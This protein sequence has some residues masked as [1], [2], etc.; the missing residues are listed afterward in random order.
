MKL[1][2]RLAGTEPPPRDA[3][4]SP[5]GPSPASGR[6]ADAS[7]VPPPAPTSSPATSSTATS[8]GASSAAPARGDRRPADPARAPISPAGHDDVVQRRR[9]EQERAQIWTKV[10][11]ELGPQLAL[12]GGIDESELETELTGIIERLLDEDGMSIPAVERARFTRSVLSD[13]LGYGPLDALLQDPDVDEVMCNRYDDVWVERRGRLE[14]TGVAFLDPAQFRHI[15]ERIVAAVGRR[16]DES[17]PMVDARLPDGARINAVLPPIAVN[18]PT[19]TIRKFRDDPFTMD[20]LI[21]YGTLSQGAAQLLDACV[22][23]ELSMIVSGGTGAGK[24]TLLNALSGSIPSDERI[25]TIED[26]AELQLQQDHVITM[27]SRPANVEGRGQVTI[28]DLVRNAL[29]MRPDR[30]VVGEVRGDEAL[31]MLQAM[32]TGHEGSLTTVHANTPR[33]AISRIETLCLMS[34]VELPERAIREQL[35]SAIDVIVQI[36]RRPDGGRR[37][38]AITEVQGLEGKAVLLQDVF[39]YDHASDRLQPTGLRPQLL[40]KLRQRGITVPRSALL[41][42]PAEAGSQD[43]PDDPRTVTS[44]RPRRWTP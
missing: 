32:N 29:R 28:R 39:A 19:L 41:D 8:A 11:D 22:R 21:E 4:S 18:G 23:G 25:I 44:P 14:R 5:P 26:A 43:A 35:V 20:A 40:D 9:W 36:S 37:I 7:E 38:M 30:I 16:V 6:T 13:L 17:S 33:D 24:T 42:A 3:A 10:I 15:I 12:D 2:E 31:D 27:E 1:S 34:G